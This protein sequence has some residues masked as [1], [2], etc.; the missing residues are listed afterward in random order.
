MKKEKKNSNDSF[1][2]I[3]SSLIGGAI[4]AKLPLLFIY[5][6]EIF[7]SP[8]GFLILLYGKTILGALIGG[9]LGVLL[10]KNRLN[11]KSKLGNII[12]PSIAIGVAI[13]RIG[14]FLRG[15]CYGKPTSLPWG[16][17]FGDGIL[18]HPTQLYESIFMFG[19]FFFLIYKK[20]Q[21]P[22]PGSLF[23]IL[24][25]SYFTF[26]FFLEFLRVEQVAFLGL[27]YFQYIC[28]LCVAW[29]LIKK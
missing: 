22:A 15:C 17:N 9:T 26:R 6:R 19:M 8:N 2:I 18:R 23:K 14:C 20:K 12:A 29:F 27:T 7:F 4:G 1:Y 11:I 10:V 3:I 21:N 13:G 25:I 5:W 24:I 28:I 16:V